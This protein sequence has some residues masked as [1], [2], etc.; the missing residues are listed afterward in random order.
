MIKSVKRNKNGFTLI[1]LLLVIALVVSLLGIA[2]FNVI[3]LT[4]KQK[5][6]S[7]ESVKEQVITAAEQYFSSNEYLFDGISETGFGIIPVGELVKED[8]LNKLTNPV[9]GLALNSCDKVKAKRNSNG[10]FDFEFITD[11][12]TLNC[13][14]N[15]VEIHSDDKAPNLELKFLKASDNTVVSP[16]GNNWFKYYVD[17]KIETDG[18]FMGVCTGDSAS[19]PSEYGVFDLSSIT[20]ENLDD[21]YKDKS[22]YEKETNITEYTY[23]VCK[24]NTS[25]CTTN[26]IIAGVDTK[27]PEVSVTLDATNTTSWQTKNGYSVN[28]K[29]DCSGGNCSGVEQFYG[30]FNDKNSK[31]KNNSLKTKKDFTI[32]NKFGSNPVGATLDNGYRYFKVVAKDAAGNE[33]SAVESVWID[34]EKPTCTASGVTNKWYNTK[35]SLTF[36]GS[37]SLSDIDGVKKYYP[38]KS[39]GIKEGT[40]KYTY[41]FKDKAGNLSDECSSTV[42]YDS[43]PPTCVA[44]LDKTPNASGWFNNV[45]GKP[46]LKFEGTDNT[47]GVKG[48]NPVSKTITAGENTYSHTFYD[49]AGNSTSCSQLVKYSDVKPTCTLQSSGI[50]KN[51]TY[52]SKNYKY[53]STSSTKTNQSGWYAG[54]V[55]VKFSSS[56]SGIT[57]YGISTSSSATYNS[58]SSATHTADTSST[59]YY[60]YVKDAS[61]N[62]AT[63]SI[64][65]KKDS[66]PPTIVKKEAGSVRCCKTSSCDGL[67]AWGYSVEFKDNLSGAT[68]RGTQYYSSA[69]CT[70]GTFYW[71]DTSP[72]TTSSGSSAKKVSAFAG[73]SNNPNPR[74]RYVLKDGAGNV[75]NSGNY[76]EMKATTTSGLTSSGKKCSTSYWY[77]VSPNRK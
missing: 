5:E 10:T 56:L 50:V 51:V 61:G 35:P 7:Y 24:N 32:S 65:I 62:T 40:N 48:T 72:T 11:N 2:V 41:R 76:F 39:E 26:S 3:K 21:G 30:Q 60:G 53:V 43:L 34:R 19:C 54:N 77:N 14:F 8:Y 1:E 22:S 38:I 28:A 25:S 49:N 20:V 29:D 27:K 9:T 45:T 74:F 75:Y 52:D 18:I 15:G 67:N 36:N 42:K 58:K 31:Y 23:K 46:T 13:Q 44:K 66:T 6:N 33:N 69:N 71:A 70:A 73:C 59:T 64:T 57:E 47:S 55:T 63:C 17:V 4:N 68:L 12:T 37:D 16:N